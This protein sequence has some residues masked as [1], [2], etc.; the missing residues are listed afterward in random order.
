MS[1]FRIY[2]DTL[3]PDLWD[4][5]M[6]LDPKIRVNLLQMATDFY[7]KTQ[8]PAPIVD[9]Y[10]MGSGANYNWTPDS[11][12][13]VHVIIDYSKL[14]MPTETANKTVKTAGAQWNSEHN[15]LIKGHKVEMNLQNAAEQKPYVTGIY[16]LIQDKW[17]RHPV[18]IPIHIDK[19]ILKF[20]YEA[21]KQYIQNCVGSG[22]REQMKAAKKYLDAYRQYGLDTYGE[23]SY[24]N[25]IYKMLRARGFIKQLKDSIISV[26]DQ[27]MTVD[28]V[29]E[30]DI[31]Q[32]QPKINVAD[33]PELG[34][35]DVDRSYWDKMNV[36]TGFKLERLTLDELKALREKARRGMSANTEWSE[37]YNADF[38]LYDAEIKKRLS[39]IN[40]PITESPMMT[41]HGKNAMAGDKPLKGSAVADVMGNIVMMRQPTSG[42]FIAEG[43]TM[44]YFMDS[45]ESAEAMAKGKI[46]YLMVPR[47]TYMFGGSPITD[48]WNKKYQKPG[49]EHILGLLEGH[50]DNERIYVD[51]ISVRPGWKRNHIAKLM[52]D[53]LKKSF[54]K[55]KVSTSTQTTDGEKLFKGLGVPK[56]KPSTNEGFGSGVP[57]D[58]RL[59]IKNTD[60]STRRW[61]VRSKDAPKTPKFT[62]E[63]VIAVPEYDKPQK[64]NE[65]VV[66]NREF[67]TVSSGYRVNLFPDDPLKGVTPEVIKAIKMAERILDKRSLTQ[68]YFDAAY[69]QEM[70]NDV[71]VSELPSLPEKSLIPLTIE[72]VKYLARDFD[73][74]YDGRRI[75]Q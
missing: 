8:F 66:P 59:K 70:V 49:H 68:Q 74:R 54:E 75:G 67:P 40:A 31:N 45:E 12:V 72:I 61:Q 24:E 51:M 37:L 22:D 18:K 63:E 60:G 44:V 57:E 56:P 65:D 21:M 25:I 28:E 29:G 19:P 71:V 10:L 3:C 58:D 39:Y 32:S 27:Q 53:R 64:C 1:N 9:V 50:T 62:G 69:V 11:D 17:L 36:E 34:S 47:G 16:S 48:V 73:I 42:G 4:S 26:Y 30:K 6:H 7:E 38:Q 23:L 55:A 20:Q 33:N 15:V 13:D 52:I 43:W 2:N 41:K 14:Q 46:P 5:A 35:P